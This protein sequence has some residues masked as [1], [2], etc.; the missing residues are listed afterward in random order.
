MEDSGG[1]TGGKKYKKGG[2]MKNITA[3]LALI[4]VVIFLIYGVYWAGKTLTYSLFYES[5]VK[6]T[7]EEMVKENSLK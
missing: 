4:V 5:I 7:I 3:H 6:Q 2:I 1:I